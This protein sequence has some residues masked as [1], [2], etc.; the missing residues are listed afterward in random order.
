MTSSTNLVDIRL[1]GAATPDGVQVGYATQHL[2]S[3]LLGFA[4]GD[5]SGLGVIVR[6]LVATARRVSST[7]SSVRYEVRHG[8]AVV[9]LEAAEPDHLLVMRYGVVLDDE[10]AQWWAGL[11]DEQ[12]AQVKQAAEDAGGKHNVGLLGVKVLIDTHC[13]VGPVGTKWDD[14]PE[15]AWTWPE[16]LRRFVLDQE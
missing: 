4:G 6:D 10:V 9:V 14:N 7:D 8:G 1:L 2:Y 5:R 12:R 3:D 15:Y 11:N 16:S 13:P